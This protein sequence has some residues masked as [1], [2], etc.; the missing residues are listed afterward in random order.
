MDV[1][2]PIVR[3]RA[4]EEKTRFWGFPGRARDYRLKTVFVDVIVL[5]ST[6]DR[7]QYPAGENKEGHVETGSRERKAQGGYLFAI[8][9]T[10]IWSGN[11]IIARGL[12]ASIS[13]VS[14]AFFRWLLAA[15]AILP[16]ALR[17]LVAERHII[18]KNL[19]YLALTSFLG[20]TTFNTLVYLAG[21]TT[22]SI[23]LSLISITFPIFVVVLSR[24]FYRESLS[25]KKGIGIVLVLFGVVLLITKG[26]PSR[27][28]AL[29]FATGDLLMLS[30]AITF[31]V[32]SL[33]LRHKPLSLSLWAFQA[34]T[35][36]IGVLFLLPAFV[37]DRAVSPPLEL[38]AT[39]LLSI[40]YLGVFASLTAYILWNKAVAAI[41]P[42]RASMIYYTI[43]LFS[44]F[45][46]T[47]FLKETVTATHFYSAVLIVSGI[48][49]S[50][51]QAKKQGS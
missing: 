43:P 31:A 20:V 34:S 46:A 47:L 35:F 1:F 29:S 44:G 25:P 39:I 22:T 45:W 33:L 10:A 49:I 50:N 7:S 40:L 9:A 12:N 18:A 2:A 38:D 16:F 3:P 42:A 15:I 13:P 30:A 37:L 23:N 26:N 24:I 48:V 51:S 11:Y 32:Y 36:I 5:A 14:L 21:H 8:G 6:K 19:P 27:L 28:L 4:R 17:S 41:G